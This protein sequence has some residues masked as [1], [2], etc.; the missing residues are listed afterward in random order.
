MTTTAKLSANTVDVVPDVEATVEAVYPAPILV[1]EHEV[2]FGTAA[3]VPVRSPN[4]RLWTRPIHAVSTT[5]S[6]TVRTSTAESGPARRDFQ[7]RYPFLENALMSR[8]MDRL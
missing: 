7:R 8:Q 1:T 3:A 6:G 4:A 2:A 5:V